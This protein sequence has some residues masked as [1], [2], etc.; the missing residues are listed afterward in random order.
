[1]EY[2]LA[3]PEF[4]IL[5]VNV[6]GKGRYDLAAYHCISIDHGHCLRLHANPAASAIV[7]QD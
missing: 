3:A 4:R 2:E 6:A 7:E 1:M 5:T